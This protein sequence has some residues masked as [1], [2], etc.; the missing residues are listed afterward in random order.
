MTDVLIVGGGLAGLQAAA[1]LSGAGLKVTLLEARDVLGGRIR[2]LHLPGAELPIELGAEFV[3]GRPPE[4][5]SVAD[6]AGL[7]LQE[8][9]GTPWFSNQGRL[10]PCAEFFAQ[11][12]QIMA[13]LAEPRYEDRSFQK[14]IEECCPQENESK[15]HAIRYVEGFHAARPERIGVRG[16]VLG[17]E[18]SA[19]IDGEKQYWVTGGYDALVRYLRAQ[20]R[21]LEICL[22][23][24]VQQVRRRPH[25]VEIR[26][27]GDG[28]PQTFRAA[29]ALITLPLGV[30]QAPAGTPGSVRFEPELTEKRAAL[31]LLEMGPVMRITF[32]FRQRF[33]ESLAA[34]RLRDM[35][36]L[37]SREPVVPTWW[38]K[39]HSRMLTGWAGGPNA[40]RLA[41]CS[42]TELSEQALA[43]L[44]RVLGVDRATVEGQVESA[45]AHD[46]IRDP[47]CRGGYSYL[48][49][50]G[51]DAPRQLA[52]PLAGTLYFAGEAT[53]FTGH[54]G[55]VNGALAS[56]V[57]AANEILD[58]LR[59]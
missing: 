24:V 57:R 17:E 16:L 14:F 45:H 53:E 5:L 21:D 28:Q 23:T 31:S 13:R 56:G 37:F 50:G 59:S 29:R 44:A 42:E 55:T 54:H 19:Q 36:F 58:S 43:T 32:R 4:V 51:I 39:L 47:Y 2:T 38:A 40:S 18:A 33:W 3:H 30:L 10:E 9:S 35:S 52:A 41:G 1:L 7:G 8:V 6:A 25:E 49:V 20:A 27:Q 46:W 48:A 11:I 12:E 22:K 26:A 15:Q 34:G